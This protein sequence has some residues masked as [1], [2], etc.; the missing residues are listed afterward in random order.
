MLRIKGNICAAQTY[1]PNTKVAFVNFEFGKKWKTLQ[2]KHR[3]SKEL[4]ET[5][6]T[7]TAEN[8]EKNV[9]VLLQEPLR[10]AFGVVCC[11]LSCL[12]HLLFVS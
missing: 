1:I 11:F 3:R 7:W 10:I 2:V 5:Q 12:F 9:L 4:E 8:K 6:K